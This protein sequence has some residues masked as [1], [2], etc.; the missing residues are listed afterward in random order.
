MFVIFILHPLSSYCTVSHFHCAE[1][2]FSGNLLQRE[3]SFLT[4]YYWWQYKT[5][6]CRKYMAYFFPYQNMN[7]CSCIR[8]CWQAQWAI[9]V[10]KY[11]RLEVGGMKAQE[12]KITGVQ[13]DRKTRKSDIKRKQALRRNK[14]RMIKQHFRRQERKRRQESLRHWLSCLARLM[15][16][17][18]MMQW[19]LTWPTPTCSARGLRVPQNQ[20]KHTHKGRS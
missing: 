3:K 5:F 10:I 15:L 18:R 11:G 7:T 1:S 17:S 12:V 6:K 14:P 20:W 9:L 8:I 13:V 2:T 16:M 4:C 19:G